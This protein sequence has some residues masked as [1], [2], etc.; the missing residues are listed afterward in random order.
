MKETHISWLVFL[1]DRVYKIKKPVAFDFLDWTSVEAREDACR[2]EVDLNRRLAPEV[3][4]GVGHF[5]SP[6][7][8][9]EPVVVMARLD[10]EASLT[11][12]IRRGDPSLPRQVE[13]I[14]DVMAGFHRRADRGPDIDRDC[15]PDRVLLLWTRNLVELG[16]AAGGGLTE[17]EAYEM[18]LAGERYLQGR[19]AL[20]E[21]RIR[22]R[23]AVDGHGD[24]LC[25]DVFCTAE[26]PRI[27]DCLEFDPALRHVDTAAD[28]AT[29]AMDLEHRGR[30][31][32]AALLVEAYQRNA[33]DNWPASLTHF[34]VAYRA[35]VRAKVGFYRAAGSDGGEAAASRA[36]ARRL[37]ELAAE[38]LRRA[39]LR[40]VL[41]GGLPGTGKSTLARHLSEATGWR[42]L[43]TDALRRETAAV[44][45]ESWKSPYG[46][47]PYAREAVDANYRELLSRGSALLR[48]GESVILDGSWLR[49]SWRDAAGKMARDVGA[50]L[51][52]LECVAPSSVARRR[53]VERAPDRRQF[54]DATP[55][56]ADA[57]ENER[58]DWPDAARIDTTG[59]ESQS[60]AAALSAVG[61]VAPCPGAAGPRRPVLRWGP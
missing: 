48:G 22:T 2:S 54:S 38:H 25:D 30:P 52:A 34:W 61:A 50:E 26:G 56:V 6:N 28:I 15:R 45:P 1:G 29:L 58:D 24:L 31:D 37:V 32:L 14:A 3:Y 53:I 9:V 17:R 16:T 33:D 51:V 60:L 20:L 42:L 7:G 41:V 49:S 46:E 43:G 40:A 19:T 5:T 27:L 55:S 10:E 23:R 39:G 13:R 44:S 4:K 11:S 36:D 21:Q 47:G 18:T 59:P 8:S 12:M 57:M 35:L